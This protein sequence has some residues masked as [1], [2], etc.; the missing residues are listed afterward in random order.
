MNTFFKF[1]I[2]LV[3]VISIYLQIKSFKLVSFDITTSSNR[4]TST[5]FK[6]E[7]C[8]NSAS[9]YT[10]NTQETEMST[11]ISAIRQNATKTPAKAAIIFLH[12]L[13]DSGQGWS[14]L[15]QLINQTQLIPDAQSINYVFPNAPQLPITVNGGMQMPAWFDIYEFGNPNAKQDINGFFK[16]CDVLKSLIQEQIDK[17]NIP[18]HKIIIGGFSQGAAISLATVLLLGYKIGGVVALSG[19]CSVGAELEQRLVKDVNFETPIFQGHGTAD[20]IIA[21]DFGK[22]TSEFYH[23]LGFKSIKFNTYPGVAHS[24]SEEELIDVV[25]FLKDIMEK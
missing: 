11:T 17:F 16:S 13:G 5:D 18:P 25:K 9:I 7:S 6:R 1:T 24:A 2:Y 19:F 3:I 21:Y 12:G 22:R 23:K 10:E 20:P 15:P 14:W 8:D 4:E